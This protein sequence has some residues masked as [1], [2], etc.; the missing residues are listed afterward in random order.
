MEL[1]NLLEINDKTV[2]RDRI[3]PSQKPSKQAEIY[4]RKQLNSIIDQL[5]TY[6]LHR[7]KPENLTDAVEDTAESYVNSFVD[8]LKELTLI[9][10][11]NV[12]KVVANRYIEQ[13]AG[14]NREQVQK[15]YKNAFGIDLGGMLSN[16]SIKSVIDVSIQSNIDLISSIRTDFINDISSHVFAS[17]KKGGNYNDLAKIIYERGGVTKNRAKFIARD[18]SAKINA[19]LTEA[20]EK[21]LG[22]DLYYWQGANDERERH[23]HRVLNGKLCKYSDSTVYSDDGGKT[24]LKRSKIGGYEGKVGTDYNCRCASRPYINLKDYDL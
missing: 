18:Q 14:Y 5:I 20:R 10:L 3:L 4:Y 24:W 19:D 2:K 21:A 8:I 22:N 23:S 9:N 7:L 12:S 17:F 13:M 1:A 15:I 16:E 11:D 6:T